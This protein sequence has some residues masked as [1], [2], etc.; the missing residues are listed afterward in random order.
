MDP[1][2]QAAFVVLGLLVPAAVWWYVRDELR[3]RRRARA[4]VWAHQQMSAVETLAATATTPL[5]PMPAEEDDP[6]DLVRAYM[7]GHGD[8][9]EIPKVKDLGPEPPDS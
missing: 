8:T 3:Q 5:D 2:T 1:L 6:P 7:W 9:E 4:E